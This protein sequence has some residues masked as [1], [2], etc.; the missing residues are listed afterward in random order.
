[1]YS[2]FF[3]DINI[4]YI[5]FK[6]QK[7]SN[8]ICIK[9]NHSYSSYLTTFVKHIKRN[10]GSG[11]NISESLVEFV[12]IPHVFKI[13]SAAFF[14]HSIHILRSRYNFKKTKYRTLGTK[15]CRKHQS[16]NQMYRCLRPNSITIREERGIVITTDV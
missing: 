10:M 5:F 15:Q 7:S 8:F 6:D 11:V 14:K 9:G 13:A 2:V 1:M 12:T 16:D 3:S 4:E